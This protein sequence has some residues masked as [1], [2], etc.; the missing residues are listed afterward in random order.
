MKIAIGTPTHECK[1]YGVYQWLNSIKYISFS[2]PYIFISDNSDT[3]DFCNRIKTYCLDIGLDAKVV[4]EPD[5]IGKEDEY[6]RMVSRESVRLQML[7]TDFTHWLSWECDILVDPMALKIIEP[8]IPQFETISMSYPSREPGD[9]ELV[10]GIGF[11]LVERKYL[12]RHSFLLNG[13]YGHCNPNRQNCY[14]SGDSWFMQRC[15]FHDRARHADF[16]N[17]FWIDHLR[18]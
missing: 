9:E 17:L 5:L 7:T 16:S 13:G 2:I 4:W 18:Q 8:Y 3:P 1:E 6:R 10:G 11:S 15:V 12:E 14:Y